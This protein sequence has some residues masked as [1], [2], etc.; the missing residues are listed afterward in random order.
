MLDA[1][2]VVLEHSASECGL[3]DDLANVFED[4]VVGLKVIVRAEAVALFFGLDYGDAGVLLPLESLVLATIATASGCADD[5][6]DTS[7]SVDAILS[8]SIINPVICQ[9][10]SMLEIEEK[11]GTKKGEVRV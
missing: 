8:A 1:L 5:T 9:V 7:C 4:K 2:L 6:L 3:V 11:M 10:E